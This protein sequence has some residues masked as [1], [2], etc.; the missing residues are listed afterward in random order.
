MAA[1]YTFGDLNVGVQRTKNGW[2]QVVLTK[3]ELYEHHKLAFHAAVMEYAEE[4]TAK[5]TNPF[6]D[7]DAKIPRGN[8]YAGRQL[9]V[10]VD[11]WAH[12]IPF[13]NTVEHEVTRVVEP[14]IPGVVHALDKKSKV[15]K[16]KLRVK[17]SFDR[18]LTQVLSLSTKRGFPIEVIGKRAATIQPRRFK[19]RKAFGVLTK[20]EKGL[21]HN[22]DMPNDEFLNYVIGATAR[23]Q[24]APVLQSGIALKPG[25]SGLIY[26]P[27]ENPYDTG[28]VRGIVGEEICDARA[29]IKKNNYLIKHLSKSEKNS[30][31]TVKA[32]AQITDHQKALGKHADGS[33]ED[34]STVKH[35]PYCNPYAEG[36]ATHFCQ[37]HYDEPSIM[38]FR[39]MLSQA[40]FPQ[41]DPRCDICAKISSERTQE[42][43]LYDARNSKMMQSLSLDE[44]NERWKFITRTF[45][46]L[47]SESNWPTANYGI[48]SEITA[49]C[50]G[51]N[52]EPFR[53]IMQILTILAEPNL[54]PASAWQEATRSLLQ[55]ARY[56]KNR[57]ENMMVG[58]SVTFANPHP[59]IVYTREPRGTNYA[60]LGGADNDW[61]SKFSVVKQFFAK[62]YEKVPDDNFINDRK[63]RKHVRGSRQLAVMQRGKPMSMGG[64][65]DALTEEEVPYEKKSEKCITTHKDQYVYSCSCVTARDGRP[66]LSQV[67]LASTGLLPMARA[68]EF[69]F[70]P[71]P[72]NWDGDYWIAKEGYCYVNIFVAM[73]AAVRPNYIGNLCELVTNIIKILKEWPALHEVALACMYICNQYSDVQNAQLPPLLVDHTNRTIHVIDT[74]GSTSTGYH[75]LKASTPRQ[76]IILASE[77][78]KGEIKDYNVGGMNLA[79]NKFKALIRSTYNPKSFLDMLESSPYYILYGAL[80]PTVLTQLY[81]SDSLTRAARFFANSDQ[82]LFQI[83]CMLENLARKVTKAQSI[84][85]QITQLHAIYPDIIH[86]TNAIDVATPQRSVLFKIAVDSIRRTHELNICDVNLAQGGYSTVNT[87]WRRK[88]EEY[89]SGIVLDCYR[90]LSSLEKLQY[91]WRTY[92]CCINTGHS[93]RRASSRV[94][95]PTWNFCTTMCSVT[96][97]NGLSKFKRTKEGTM[98]WIG[99]KSSAACRK[100]AFKTMSAITPEIG[101]MIGVLTIVSVLLTIFHRLNKIIHQKRVA[102]T[103]LANERD[104]L[105]FDKVAMIMPLYEKSENIRPDE[106]INFVHFAHWVGKTDQAMGKF[107]E[108]QFTDRVSHQDKSTD[109]VWMEKCI[110]LMVLI[111]MLFDAQKSDK[112]YNILCRLRTIFTTMGQTVVT[113]QSLDDILDVE[114]MKTGTVDFVR[115]ESMEPKSPI[116]QLTFEKYWDNQIAQGRTLAHYRTVGELVEVTRNTITDAVSTIAA[117]NPTTEFIVRGGVGAG[118]STRLPALLSE[119]GRLL[120]I[121]PT[122]PLTENVAMQLRGE[123]HYKSPNVHMRG[124]H[125]FGSSPITIMT[126]GYALHY[127]ANNRSL[128]REFEFI[129]IDECHVMDASAMAFYSLCKDV[130]APSKIL[131]VSATPPGRE[132]EF[133][134]LHTVKV[135]VAESLSFESFVQAQGSG[136]TFDVVQHGNDILVYVA[137]Y[138]EVDRLTNLLIDKHYCVTKVDGRTMRLNA[139][140]I[141]MKGSAAKKHFIVATNIIENGVTLDIDCLVDF[142]TK[143]VAQ[144][145]VEGRRIAYTK[146]PIS[147][148]ERI[149]RVGRVGR[150]KP[151]AALKIGH[152]H[153]GIVEIPETVATEAAFLCFMYDLPVMTGQVSLNTLSRCTREQ[154]KTMAAFELSIF[155]MATLIAHDGTMHPAIH[156]LLKK[157]KLRDSVITLRRSSLPLRAASN[158][159]TVKE[160][161][162][163]SGQI[164]IADKSTKIPFMA[165]DLSHREYEKLWH[166]IQANKNDVQ[167]LRMTTMDSQRIAYTLQTDSSSIQRTLMIVDELISEENR[168]REMFNIYTSNSTSG[169]MF[170]LNAIA[171]CAKSRYAEKHCNKNIETLTSIRN[172]LVE[173]DSLSLDSFTADVI[174]NYPC[175]TLVE[176]QSKSAIAK[177]LQL[178]AKYDTTLMVTDA[179]LGIG[180]LVGGSAML[181]K[182]FTDRVQTS[183]CFEADGK[184]QQQK[185]KFRAA[186]D[187][188]MEREVYADDDT[189]AENYGEAYTKKG[190]KGANFEKGMGSKKREFTNFY[191]FTPEDYE[192][193]RYV[194]PITGAT[195]DMPVNAPMR[196]R[197]IE[198]LFTG[199][200]EE[201]DENFQLPP[202]TQYPPHALQAYFINERTRLARQ[203]ELSPHNPLQVGRRT[204]NI[205]GF[206]A[207]EG[208][209]R[210][211]RPS[212]PINIQ[213]VP[214]PQN[215]VVNHESKSVIKGMR[216]Y[217]PITSVI[218][219]L[220]FLYDD[221]SNKIHGICF[222]SYIITTSHLVVKNGGW[223]KINT[224]HG[225]F[226]ISSMDRVQIRQVDGSD[227]IIIKCPKDMP[228]SPQKLQFRTPRNGERVVLIGHVSADVMKPAISDSSV[229]Y[230]REKTNFWKHWISTKSGHCGLPIISVDTMEIVGLHS[231]TANNSAENYFAAFSEDF[232]AR[233]LEEASD[234]PWVRKWSYNRDT[235]NW[236]TMVLEDSKPD[237]LFMPKKAVSATTDS[238]FHQSNESYTWLTKYIGG[239]LSVVG[240]CPGNLITKHVVKGKSQM[241]SLYLSVDEQARTFFQPNLNHYAP[242]RLNKEAF[243]KDITKYDETIKVGDLN[244]HLFEEAVRHTDII[245]RE[246]GIGLCNYVTDA[247]EV[248]D[249]MNMK[250]ATGALY[251]G[252]KKDYFKDFTDEMKQ[253]I[254]KE[255]YIRLRTG[256][257]GIW[258]GSLKAELRPVEKVEANKTRVFT[259]APLDTLLAA[260]GCVDDFNNQFYAGNLKG[261]WTVGISKFYGQWDKFLRMLP[262]GWVYFDADGSRFDSSLTPYLINAVLNLR[263]E[264]MEDWD[265]GAQCL[266]NLYTEIIYTPIATPD[267]S[268]IKKHRGNNS[269]Q[270]STVVDN[271]IM[272]I[273][274]VQYAILKAG[275]TL[276]DQSTYI[277]YFANGDDLVIAVA[278]TWADKISTFASSFAE[279]GLNYDFS[280]TVGTREELSF[281]SHT[282]KLIDGMHIPMLDRERV[283]AIL[284]WDRSLEPQFQMDSICAAI[285]EAWGDDELLL[286]IQRFYAW[287]LEQEPYKSLATNGYAPYISAPALLALY[288]GVEAPDEMLAIYEKASLAIPPTDYPVIVQHES[289]DTTTPAAPSTG[290]VASSSGTSSPVIARPPATTESPTGTAAAR[291][292][293]LQT[294]QVKER[295]RRLRESQLSVRGVDDDK[296]VPDASEFTVPR[297]QT[298]ARVGKFPMVR[299]KILLNTDHLIRYKPDQR[300][301][302]NTRA[303][304]AQ[305]EQWYLGIQKELEK[306]DEEM[307]IIMNGFMVWAMENGTSP[308]LT[309]TWTMMEGTDQVEFQLEPF[310]RHAQPTLRQIMYHFSDAAVAY[311]VMRNQTGRYM[312][313]YGIKRN[314]NNMSLAPYAF[315]F[316]ELSASSPAAAREAHMQMKAAA[317]RGKTTRTFGLDGN[318]SAQNENTERHTVQDVNPK[319]HSLM[320]TNML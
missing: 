27:A 303:T 120:M 206:P 50:C 46:T 194:D 157:F 245:L 3:D 182:I 198:E 165:N 196:S 22:R 220:E 169:F 273:L 320:G 114:A 248:F 190:R 266:A 240:K 17:Y 210:Q 25:D 253:E 40:F 313:R 215:I 155:T 219:Q 307:S 93:L 291:N 285:I 51:R 66:Y 77:A 1:L 229:T 48:S 133:K 261:P 296:D 213:D 222:G 201:L 67:I 72:F 302:A 76:L 309:G 126:S 319:L 226:T 251:G 2:E 88:K 31:S 212:R 235:I 26:R 188:K 236:G 69:D 99:K 203:V 269:G 192:I 85:H 110:A 30:K 314:L 130:L 87:T 124:L 270:P 209:F 208:E 249:S 44:T 34:D 297:T 28:V 174:R 125:T 246:A 63:E 259:A 106:E 305:F 171:L 145:D 197:E 308:D 35:A 9:Q 83:V 5:N 59:P 152:T 7:M 86:L 187:N 183:V 247:T 294:A 265:F 141:E 216:D 256:K 11:E 275:G 128:L 199:I 262:D 178:E 135:N 32:E 250:A 300:D 105:M 29:Y 73:I 264:F 304:Q 223:L 21:K 260:K 218:C 107:I 156:E 154:A 79:P 271:T 189:I 315:D 104:D 61:G 306:T 121:E 18:L 214:P 14:T 162:S 258:N 232:E 12:T 116:M 217:N 244:T 24:T 238:V 205:A 161:E 279:L 159:Y 148:G 231:L 52:D 54:A 122:R 173:F 109:N 143:V 167:T 230:R 58:S 16:P 185:L 70:I 151:G 283:C 267:G 75:V 68:D 47:L 140:G 55:L 293:N 177:T 282:G 280:N 115:T 186:R 172:Q 102:A 127:Y 74:F 100:I 181:Y 191:G 207:R 316:Y 263:L 56:M 242:S 98:Q 38:Q 164:D 318:V 111:T 42:R 276:D 6:A 129:V 255:S 103:A 290:A 53:N 71:I 292:D 317:I 92:H 139:Q 180:T 311:A 289:A 175:V 237:G 239:N 78:T 123:P 286:E 176:H 118:K 41:V 225:R 15:Q 195:H 274:A 278:P 108:K 90:E 200:R 4:M 113:H 81:A 36:Y 132:C 179:L 257:L 8:S 170:S 10:K 57:E 272:V 131:K 277:K 117:S 45:K 60:Y 160:Y 281:M 23:M 153:K 82:N 254:L 233:F 193:V 163:I 101:S 64:L 91:Q 95:K 221:R 84:D 295:Q 94:L 202:G 112:L 119:R 65:R 243:V 62:F 20:H 146:M 19:H 144:L 227:I 138:P 147:Y 204:N 268:V 234:E 168:K 97:Q 137:S 288:T 211:D 298:I 80:S 252:K 149:Q 284:E 224:K 299:G 43:I 142:G 96:M 241:F 301:L 49:I 184:R 287:L 310:L 166:T 312:P 134:P 150:I 39:E 33:S 37:I 228:P 13:K 89:L 136:S 158:W